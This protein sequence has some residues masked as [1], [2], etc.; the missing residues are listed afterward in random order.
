MTGAGGNLFLYGG[1]A[2]GWAALALFVRHQ[3]ATRVL[4]HRHRLA[5]AVLKRIPCDLTL[6][7]S[8]GPDREQKLFAAVDALDPWEL[9]SVLR[10]PWLT[11]G[12]WISP[13]ARERAEAW[14]D[15][16]SLIRRA[17]DLATA[18]VRG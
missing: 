6:L 7:L 3:L 11:T 1:A 18:A 14:R 15:G 2:A 13:E 17:F 10:F 4:R 12:L 5:K 16:R 8:R 9:A